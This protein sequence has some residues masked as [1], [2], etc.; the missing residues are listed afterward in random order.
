MHEGGE[1]M[2]GDIDG[3]NLVN[4]N[5][6][7]ALISYLLSNDATGINPQATDCDGDGKSNINDVT[8]LISYL[9][10]KSW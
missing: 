10:S 8:A 3:D 6:V 1:A 4:I 9:L 5:D 7:T 2:R